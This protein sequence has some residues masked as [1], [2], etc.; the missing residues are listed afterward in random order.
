VMTTR[1]RLSE[2]AKASY[3]FSSISR[4]IKRFETSIWKDQRRQLNHVKAFTIQEARSSKIFMKFASR[5]SW[6]R[7]TKRS[8][9]SFKRS[10]FRCFI[11][12]RRDNILRIHATRR[13]LFWAKM[14][15]IEICSRICREAT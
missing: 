12:F 14:T 2:R 11:N 4:S 7:T 6:R 15:T 8:L 10:R 5:S 1:K 3:T 9:F 13:T